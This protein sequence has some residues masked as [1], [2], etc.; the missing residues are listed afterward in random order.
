MIFSG[1]EGVDE[2]LENNN[3]MQSQS[4]AG[5][6]GS[7]GGMWNGWHLG[8]GQKGGRG[9]YCQASLLPCDIFSVVVDVKHETCVVHE[10]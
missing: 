2:V 4:I 3:W 7:D 10:T 9:P 6:A 8:R 5:F 1:A